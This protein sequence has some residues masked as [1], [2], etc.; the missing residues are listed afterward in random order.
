MYKNVFFPWNSGSL[1][2]SYRGRN[3]KFGI[4]VLA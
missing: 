3:M 1:E 2:S 4:T